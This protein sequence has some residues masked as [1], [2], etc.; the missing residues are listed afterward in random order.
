MISTRALY[1]AAFLSLCAVLATV[2]FAVRSVARRQR[3][4]GA[5]ADADENPRRSVRAAKGRARRSRESQVPMPL[6][7]AEPK[8]AALASGYTMLVQGILL[9]AAAVLLVRKLADM[10]PKS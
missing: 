4:G 3:L 9:G 2:I 10:Q 7:N 8:G 6:L 1:I 5:A